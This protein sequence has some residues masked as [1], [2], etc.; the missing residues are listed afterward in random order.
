M[1]QIGF[2]QD[3]YDDDDEP[4]LG[5]IQDSYINGDGDDDDA[6]I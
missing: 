3:S 5:F 1:I 6:D 4:M 2:I